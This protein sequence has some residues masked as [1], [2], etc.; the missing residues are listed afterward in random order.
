MREIVH[1]PQFIHL[2]QWFAAVKLGV[3]AS[4]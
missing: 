1:W 3:L 4:L 2:G